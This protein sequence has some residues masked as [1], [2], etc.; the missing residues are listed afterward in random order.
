[1]FYFFC[2]AETTW[3]GEVLFDLFSI[4]IWMTL[5]HLAMKHKIIPEMQHNGTYSENFD[6][7]NN[8]CIDS[9]DN[10]N[11]CIDNNNDYRGSNDCNDGD[12]DALYPNDSNF[13]L[14]LE[15]KLLKC[16]TEDKLFLTPQLTLSQLALA[17]KTNRTY[18]SQYINGKGESF[19]DLVNKY[20]VEEA[21]RLLNDPTL[22]LS[23]VDLAAQCGFNSISSFN[24][25][26]Y[27]VTGMSPTKYRL[28]SH[29]GD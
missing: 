6:N 19:S 4:A 9:N 17:V 7:D 24:R 5:R 25:Y 21:C 12:A 3:V 27:K 8:Y 20:R 28:K 14:A 15:N 11:D 18:L 13:E 26:F 22:N 10:S 16:M 2:F 23:M 29:E 1:M